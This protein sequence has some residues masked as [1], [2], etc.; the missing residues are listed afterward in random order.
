MLPLPLRFFIAM[1]AYALNERMARKQEYLL[2]EVRVLKEAL[3]AKTGTERITFT[4]EQRRRLALKGRALTP[5]ERRTCCQ[6]VKPETILSWFRAL[7]ASKYDSSG[8]ENSAA[9]PQS[10]RLLRTRDRHATPR[11]F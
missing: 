7:A 11:C 5:A 10:K 1:I 4:A 9:V 2:E 8:V 3:A 6:I